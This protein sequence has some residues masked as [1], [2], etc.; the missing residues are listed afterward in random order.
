MHI[1]IILLFSFFSFSA[2]AVPHNGIAPNFTL[3][4]TNDQEVNLTDFRGKFVVLEWFNPDC[5][6]IKRHYKTQTMTQLAAHY[7]RQ[8]VIWLAINSTHY[9]K[10]EDNR[11]WKDINNVP[12]QIL[13]DSDGRVGLLYQ[14]KTTPHMFIISPTGKLVYSGAIDDDPWGEQKTPIN[15]VSTVLEAL[16]H[17]KKIP[18]TTKKPYGCSVKYTPK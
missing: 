15:Y 10:P 11:R 3:T 17:N 2:I 6:F 1:W 4:D 14:A 18:Y 9:M 16:I 5:P 12:Y 7:K 8:D 13:S